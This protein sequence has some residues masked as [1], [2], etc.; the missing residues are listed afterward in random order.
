MKPK[1]VIVLLILIANSSIGAGISL[2]PTSLFL[3]SVKPGSLH[4]ISP[5]LK[6]IN[7][8]SHKNRYLAKINLSPNS[9]F[10]DPFPS[11]RWIKPESL[12]I[13]VPPDTSSPLTF[14]IEI[15]DKDE[16]FNKFWQ[17]EIL[18]SNL[19]KGIISTG[20]IVPVTIE[21]LPNKKAPIP[22]G[23][24]SIIPSVI[25]LNDSTQKI[26]IH[27]RTFTSCTLDIKWYSG[28]TLPDNTRRLKPPPEN[29]T[30]LK[31]LPMFK[32]PTNSLIIEQRS[33]RELIISKK[34]FLKNDGFLIF[35]D[36]YEIFAYTKFKK[37]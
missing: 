23:E 28:Q 13:V 5:S 24:L 8:S 37:K 20:F 27:N 15:P 9:R 1:I 12:Q 34:D 7:P 30:I 2:R 3:S 18:I 26:Y 19:S 11:K 22:D 14:S 16:Y 33:T 31:P 36:G 6:I 21:T 4:K 10:Y 32:V 35:T 17:F 25:E 29:L